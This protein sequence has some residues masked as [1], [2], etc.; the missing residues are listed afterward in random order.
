MTLVIYT[1]FAVHSQFL[2]YSQNVIL[3]KLWNN[4]YNVCTKAIIFLSN[5]IIEQSDYHF[6]CYFIIN[7][8]ENKHGSFMMSWWM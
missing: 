1:D 8:G 6:T 7:T 2:Q 4:L 5:L 3:K